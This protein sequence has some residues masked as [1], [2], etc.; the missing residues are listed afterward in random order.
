[1][2]HNLGTKAKINLD[3]INQS[4]IIQPMLKPHPF[5]IL[6]DILHTIAMVL[7]MPIAKPIANLSSKFYYT[8]K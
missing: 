7:P 3:K 5:R 8:N 1:M 4:D 6:S 2:V